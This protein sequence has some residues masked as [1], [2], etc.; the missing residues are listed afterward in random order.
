MDSSVQFVL[1]EKTLQEINFL[2]QCSFCKTYNEKIRKNLCNYCY[3]IL[4]YT[5]END[6]VIYSFASFFQSIAA[7]KSVLLMSWFD[8]ECLEQEII[9]LCDEQP[10][11]SYR[12]DKFQIY[13]D[14][15]LCTVL[16]EASVN[17]ISQKLDDI[18]NMI[19]KNLYLDQTKYVKKR[20]YHKNFLI[21]FLD[22][23]QQNKVFNFGYLQENLQN[24]CFDRESLKKELLEGVS[25]LY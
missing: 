1:Q 15:G 13:I 21:D 23:K 25:F 6:V 10:A 22:G 19:C 4:N 20:E 17:E 24:K 9:E 16:E 14:L 5:K 11:I 7:N 3:K 18:V 2:T 12:K 8:F